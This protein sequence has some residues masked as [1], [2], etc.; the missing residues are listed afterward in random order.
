MGWV[1]PSTFSLVITTLRRSCKIPEVFTL[2]FNHKVLLMELGHR[3]MGKICQ[4]YISY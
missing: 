4:I 1:R 2:R 3:T